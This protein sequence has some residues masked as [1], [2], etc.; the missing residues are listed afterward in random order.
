L[1]GKAMDLLQ[2]NF[3]RLNET[4]FG[5]GECVPEDLDWCVSR[6]VESR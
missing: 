3:N 6:A 4:L 5:H 1:L 2:C